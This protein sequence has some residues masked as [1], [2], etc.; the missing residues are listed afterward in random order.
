[1]SKPLD[2]FQ[3]VREYVITGLINLQI[4]NVRAYLTFLDFFKKVI[5]IMFWKKITSFE[6]CKM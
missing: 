4:T 2:Y 5:K 3:V 1:M 6:I